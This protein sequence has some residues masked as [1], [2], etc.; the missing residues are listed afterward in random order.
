[1]QFAGGFGLGAAVAEELGDSALLRGE[2]GTM[3]RQEA[4]EA[5]Q[6]GVHAREAEKDA[7]VGALLG[8]EFDGGT[9]EMESGAVNIDGFLLEGSVQKAE[10]EAYAQAAI[11]KAA[12]DI[13]EQ[14]RKGSGG[15]EK[16]LE[17]VAKGDDESGE[18]VVL[19]FFVEEGD[20]FLESL[21]DGGTLGAGEF[22]G[23][24]HIGDESDAG[25]VG[26]VHGKPPGNDGISCG[27]MCQ[28]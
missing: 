15:T 26:D 8:G 16:A 6:D 11:G 25:A 14:I 5:V 2:P 17:F 19:V 9:G 18:D 10:S 21:L 24:D 23:F 20:E 13:P 4:G 1:L 7:A 28:P 12:V 3:K 27:E 22:T